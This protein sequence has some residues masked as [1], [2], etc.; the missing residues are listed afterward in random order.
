MNLRKPIL[1]FLLIR[2][3]EFK[4]VNKLFLFEFFQGSAIAIY[5]T[6]SISIFL[7]HLPTTDLPKVFLLSSLLLW[8]TGFIYNKLEH[9]L[10]TSQ[11]IKTVISFNIACLL[12]IRFLMVYQNEVWF[13][14]IFLSLFNILYLL[15]NLDF[16]GL[17]AQLFDVR[18]SKRLF[19]IISA[20]DIPAKMVG[21]LSAYLISPYI[22][23]ENLLFVG[24][25]LLVVSFFI[26]KPL[27]QLANLEAHSK[28]SK[29][30]HASEDLQNLKTAIF[31]NI[32]I[33]KIAIIS[34]FS[35]SCLIIINFVFYGYVKQ[36]FKTDS[37]LVAFFSIF[38]FIIRA[39]T[40]FLKIAGTNKLVDKLGLQKSLLISPIILLAIGMG[41]IYFSVNGNSPKILFYLYGV[42]AVVIDVLRSSITTPVLLATMQP[43]PVK[44]RLR[45]HT[46][47]KGLMDP[48]AFFFMGIF[49][50][51]YGN[52]TFLDFEVLSI[53][54]L[55]LLIGWI[56][57]SLS[58]DKDYLNTLQAAIRNRSLNERDINLSDKESID[59]LITKIKKGTVD[60]GISSLKILA[61]QLNKSTK[62]LDIS[63]QH[64]SPIIVNYALDIIQEK[65]IES[66]I[67]QLKTLLNKTEDYS[68]ISKLLKVITFF[69]PK[70]DVSDYLFH[71]HHEVSFVAAFS[72][73]SEETEK[74]KSNEI[75]KSFINSEVD[76]KKIIA[77]R[78]IAELKLTNFTN[79]II[80]HLYHPKL[81]LKN[82][83]IIASGSVASAKLIQELFIL[84]N[85]STNDYTIIEAFELAKGKSVP[86]IID[87]LNEVNCSGA[88]S[89]KLI[90]SL[91]KIASEEAI[92]FLDSLLISNLE[93]VDCVATA[94]KNSVQISQH[95]KQVYEQQILK[96]LKSAVNI[97]YKIDFTKTNP[98]ICDALILEL[99]NI[100]TICLEL[101]LFLYDEKLMSK[102]KTGFK[103]SNK[104]SIANAL[105]LI[106][107]S[108][109]KE[110]STLFSILFENSTIQDKCLHLNAVYPQPHL[111]EVIVYK[112]ILF[113]INY[114]FSNW[115]KSCVLYSAKKTIHFMAN[116]FIK[117]F[118]FSKNE[119]L[120]ETAEY[121]L[122][123]KQQST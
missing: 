38:F 94:L 39:G 41:I 101:F 36:A 21:Y 120:K 74:T 72:L 44:S 79:E 119:V 35:F 118:T 16:W 111:D 57:F 37:S 32:L 95:N 96:L 25:G 28:R 19:G 116:E 113:D 99:K 48:F 34:F 60:E 63:L 26:H 10:T 107:M 52:S 33:R 112:N 98:V 82:A 91:G 93:N 92:Q 76:E 64:S 66:Y 103:D 88:K 49:L 6:C 9:A 24:A 51:L 30:N 100:R 109:P 58:I 56:F 59:F 102:A 14:Y 87:Y 20:G 78:I 89:R 77:L 65:K 42:M 117:P 43:L 8:I 5:F 23:T 31:G 61:S 2:E 68:I 104:D 85:K 122:H 1:N 123:L 80:E 12:I 11:L 13:L 46:I 75:I 71:P 7:N 110:I 62:F 40:L 54:L 115:T 121:I 27:M 90:I 45:G 3:S 81:N 97:I 50:L 105:E 108:T 67:P 70:F 73:I 4:L 47:V 86:F 17:A 15:N 22:G 84:F 83:A 55:V 69:E 53:G 29:I 18:Q 114:K 106:E